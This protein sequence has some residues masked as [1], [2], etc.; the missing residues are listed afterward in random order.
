ML[1]TRT[2]PPAAHPARM[3]LE[4]YSA[5]IRL[6]NLTVG[7]DSIHYDVFLSPRFVEFARIYLFDLVRQVVNVGLLYGGDRG[8]SRP[9]RPSILRFARCLL[10]FCRNRSRAPNFSSPSRRMFSITWRS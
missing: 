2:A 10:K 5:E 9:S 3:K 7:V 1:E 4:P 8:A 6:P